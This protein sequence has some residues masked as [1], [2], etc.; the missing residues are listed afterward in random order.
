VAA[1]YL[2]WKVY[3][4][5]WRL[6]VKVEDMDLKSGVRLHVPESDEDLPPRTWKNMPMRIVRG[7][8]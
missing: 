1:L 8:F 5:D 2:G 3:S 4:N 7:L 6:Y